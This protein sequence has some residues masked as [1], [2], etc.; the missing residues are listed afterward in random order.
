MDDDHIETVDIESTIVECDNKY[1]NYKI[2][3]V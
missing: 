2:N 1:A 3:E